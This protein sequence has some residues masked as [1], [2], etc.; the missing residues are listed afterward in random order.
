MAHRAAS[1]T[2]IHKIIPRC[3]DNETITNPLFKKGKAG[4][5]GTLTVRGEEM[6]SCSEHLRFQLAGKKLPNKVWVDLIRFEASPSLYV[7]MY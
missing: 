6:V 1:N 2:L 4:K 3:S 5:N 7:V